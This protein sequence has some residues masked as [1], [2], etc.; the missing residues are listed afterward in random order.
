MYGGMCP[1]LHEVLEFNLSTDGVNVFDK[2]W[3][4]YK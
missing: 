2:N 4:I 1:R 3:Q